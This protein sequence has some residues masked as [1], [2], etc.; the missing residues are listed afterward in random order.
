MG[1]NIERRHWGTV[2]GMGGV[3]HFTLTHGDMSASMISYGARLTSLRAPG[4]QGVGE[5][6]LGFDTL[7]AYVRDQTSMGAV[8]G[9]VAGRISRGHI[10]LGG[11]CH[12][13]DR[14]HGGHTLHG[15][16]QGFGSRVWEAEAD[17][18]TEG[19]YV[20]F[21]YFSLDGEMG[22]PGTVKTTVVYTLTENGLRM[23][24]LAESGKPTVVNLTNHAYFNLAG[25]GS[26]CLG[27]ELCFLA[28][29]C[30][31]TDEELIPTGALLNVRGTA[32]DFTRPRAMGARIDDGGLL[33]RSACGYDHYYVADRR[34]KGVE[35][36]AHVFEPGSGRNMEMRTTYPGVQFYSGNHLPEGLPGRAGETYGPRAGFCLEAQGYPDAP[37]RP[38]FPSVAL[39]PGAVMKHKTEY[40]FFVR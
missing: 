1:V 23:D 14:N 33:P 17:I 5:V 37:N 21:E 4:R 20:L 13:L 9:R 11:L 35:L 25:P 3:E 40:R 10:E 24:F 30:L 34:G 27:H 15:G 22:F 18:G 32:L 31:E 7:E 39:R 8:C 29:R 16:S 2:P 19:P 38:E 36:L 6:I 26:D 28:S 12:R